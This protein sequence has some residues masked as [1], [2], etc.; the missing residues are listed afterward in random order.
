MMNGGQIN[1]RLSHKSPGSAGVP[2]A[3]RKPETGTR[4][5]DASAPRNC[6][7]VQ[8]F[9]ARIRS[10]NSQPADA[11]DTMKPSTFDC[12]ALDDPRQVRTAIVAE[13]GS[14]AQSLHQWK[15]RF[16]APPAGQVAIFEWI[17]V[18]Y[19]PDRSG[20]HNVLGCQ[21]PV[22]FETQLNYNIHASCIHNLS[23]KSGQGRSLLGVVPR[24]PTPA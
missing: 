13:P 16:K 7:P 12:R 14:N 17:E 20:L 6:A 4:R 3:S 8:G 10:G 15:Q 1:A 22:D 11:N 5:R 21:S 23:A 18:F 19:N 2:P 24:R 9:K